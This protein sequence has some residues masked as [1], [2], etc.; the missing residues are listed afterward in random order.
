MVSELREQ[1]RAKLPEYMVPAGFVILEALPLTPN[2]KVDRKALPAPDGS[3]PDLGT[4]YVA[5][6]TETEAA[7]VEIWRA[8]LHLEQVGVHD[9]FFAIGGDS[10]LALQV[11][12]RIRERFQVELPLRELFEAPTVERV[13]ALIEALGSQGGPPEG[14]AGDDIEE[15]EL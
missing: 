8:A 12:S 9:D 10:I 2:G 5:A 1:L 4:P 6:R 11:V 14:M 15:G 13:A 7:L 3:R